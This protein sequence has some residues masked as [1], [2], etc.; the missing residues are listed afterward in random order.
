MVDFAHPSSMSADQLTSLE[1]ANLLEADRK[2]REFLNT[3][4][5]EDA[6]NTVEEA[7]QAW[8]ELACSSD[9]HTEE[10]RRQYGRLINAT[11]A[12]L[13][14][15]ITHINED[16]LP[17]RQQATLCRRMANLLEDHSELATDIPHWLPVLERQIIQDGAIV[18]HKLINT[19]VSA[20]QNARALFQRLADKFDPCPAWIQIRLNELGPTEPATE[21]PSQASCLAAADGARNV[22]LIYKPGLPIKLD[23]E[24][25]VA[26]NIAAEPASDGTDE[27]LRTFLEDIISVQSQGTHFAL[28]DPVMTLRCSA[29]EMEVMGNALEAASLARMERAAA[30]WGNNMKLLHLDDISANLGGS[31]PGPPPQPLNHYPLLIELDSLEVGVVQAALSDRE[32]IHSA[33][34]TLLGEEGNPGFWMQGLHSA[35][36]YHEQLDPLDALR[37]FRRDLG[38]VVEPNDPHESLESWLN[39]ALELFYRVSLWGEGGFWSEEPACQWMALPLI[40]AMRKDSG[41]LDPIWGGLAAQ[42]IQESLAEEDVLYIGPAARHVEDQHQ[43]GR[44]WRLYAD[45]LRSPRSLRCLEPPDSRYPHHPGRGIMQVVDD[46][47]NKI[48]PWHREKPFSVALVNGGAYRLPLCLKLNQQVGLRC[49][50]VNRGAQELFGV[51]LKEEGQ[52]RRSLNRI[53]RDQWISVNSVAE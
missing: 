16:P 17:V 49:V 5:W 42:S 6:L 53:N 1:L 35:F 43:S 34:T 28:E 4:Q 8:K 37:R 29:G 7:K 40:Q 26:F 25:G 10:F 47:M 52:S 30:L 9:S 51:E 3:Q 15:I 45:A 31:W 44:A 50:A 48:L 24:H 12:A 27:K 14:P 13:H 18:W 39:S 19:E 46:M 41:M 36:S 32:H 33:L 11:T 21:L 22:S 2:T 38:F 20:K 23:S